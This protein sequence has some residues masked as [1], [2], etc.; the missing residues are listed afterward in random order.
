V[1]AAILT[2]GLS[3]YAFHTYRVNSTTGR[4]ISKIDNQLAELDQQR[5]D[6]EQMLAL[7]QNSGTRDTAQYL[8]DAFKLKEFSW[9]QV[10]SDLEKLVPSGVQIVSIKPVVAGS[11]IQMVMEVSTGDRARVLEMVRRMESSPRFLE[12]HIQNEHPPAEGKI[13]SQIQAVYSPAGAQ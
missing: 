4:E 9:T 2:F 6:A 7:P 13:V 3:A 11:E 12:V 10:L 1:F 8:N 5:K